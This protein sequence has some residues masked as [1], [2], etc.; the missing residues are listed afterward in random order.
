MT[1][2]P[3]FTVPI[4]SAVTVADVRRVAVR[5]PSVPPIVTSPAKTTPLPPTEPAAPSV[6]SEGTAT[7]PSAPPLAARVS[8]VRVVVPVASMPRSCTP[9]PATISVPALPGVCWVALAKRTS[10]LPPP[11]R[12][13]VVAVPSASL[14]CTRRS[15]EP[16]PMRTAL[17]STGAPVPVVAT[18]VPRKRSS[19]DSLSPSV[20]STGIVSVRLSPSPRSVAL[21]VASL[22]TFSSSRS[23]SP[24][25]PTRRSYSSTPP[26]V[27]TSSP[28]APNAPASDTARLAAE[29]R[30][31]AKLRIAASPTFTLTNPPV[32]LS[33]P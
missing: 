8:F 3:T 22:S 2:P 9:L 23:T 27:R 15:S 17:G 10:A 18:S 25:P 6:V 7:T 14:N 21:P 16:S 12:V 24:S 13:T 4:E 31:N 30:S 5:V 20:K 1:S 28:P 26:V 11:V 33:M 19:G 29:R 32:S